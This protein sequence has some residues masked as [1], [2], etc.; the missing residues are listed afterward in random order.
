ML[1]Q[2]ATAGTTLP[3]RISRIL[4]TANSRLNIRWSAIKFFVSTKL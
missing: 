3:T 2:T 1:F 4:M